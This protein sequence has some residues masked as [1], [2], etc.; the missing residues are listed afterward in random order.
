[1]WK[2]FFL[3]DEKQNV[4]RIFSDTFCG[5]SSLRRHARIMNYTSVVL[6]HI[7]R[8]PLSNIKKYEQLKTEEKG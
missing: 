6:T 7:A 4:G 5:F 2:I 8:P 3:P 1:M